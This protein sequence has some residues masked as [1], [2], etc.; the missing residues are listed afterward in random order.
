MSIDQILNNPVLLGIIALSVGI[1]IGIYIFRIVKDEEKDTIDSEGFAP[2]FDKIFSE[3]TDSQGSKIKD[4]VKIRGIS[5]T[6]RTLGLAFKA[7]SNDINIVKYDSENEEYRTKKSE[8][9]TYRI[10]EG[11]GKIG[12]KIKSFL[13]ENLS[14]DYFL[15][16][17]DVPDKLKTVGEDYIWL[18]KDAHFVKFNGI[19]RHLDVE[20]LSRGWEVSFS[21]VHE[22]LLE[23]R[24][25]IPE[26]Y[27][28]LNNRISGQLL[29]ENAKSQ[30]FMEF[31]KMKENL[32]KMDA[33]N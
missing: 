22:N 16:T 7:K 13:T 15:T 29:M 17:Y 14:L 19:K 21:K 25:D 18:N 27:A 1:A 23:T 9:T 5:S 30:N 32:E 3:A 33:V 6:P 31:E 26:Q 2:K 8:G 20:G 10:I 24:G 28:V 4:Y 12:L 11:S